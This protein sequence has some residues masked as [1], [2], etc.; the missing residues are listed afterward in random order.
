M[1]PGLAYGREL[2]CIFTL[3]GLR[4]LLLELRPG[5]PVSCSI[6]VLKVVFTLPHTVAKPP[7]SKRQA[8][9]HVLP[10]K[11]SAAYKDGSH[12]S[13]PKV[14]ARQCSSPVVEDIQA[15]RG[16]ATY[17][18]HMAVKDSEPGSSSPVYRP[19]LFQSSSA[20]PNSG[21]WDRELSSVKVTAM[22]SGD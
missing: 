19:G 3:R 8:D 2:A 22:W 1:W 4:G 14:E 13:C 7:G 21:G 16:Y 5:P 20:G 11:F 15:Q 6:P 9:C 18:S 12:L 17:N 10:P